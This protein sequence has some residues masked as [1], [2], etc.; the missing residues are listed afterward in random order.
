MIKF[1]KNTLTELAGL[2]TGAVAASYVQQ[3]L[4]VKADGTSVFG[5]STSAGI[6]TDAAPAVVG[7]F[8]QGQPGIFLKEAGKGMIAA[9]IG[10]LIK[11]Q[12]ADTLGINGM[13]P[14][15]QGADDSSDDMPMMGFTSDSYDST[16]GN[17]GEMDF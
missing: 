14:F 16:S 3:K 17:A 11:K 4:L 12:F 10:G 6:L 7:L 5:A 15:I 8:L 2:G 1:N 9:S 13:D